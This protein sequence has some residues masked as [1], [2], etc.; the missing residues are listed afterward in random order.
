MSTNFKKTLATLVLVAVA[1]FG[2]VAPKSAKADTISDL[3]AQIAALMA[4]ISA[5]SGSSMTTTCAY[6][7]TVT[8]KV[9]STGS[10][11]SAMQTVIG[12][13]ADGKFGPNTK[14]KV[15]AFQASHGLVADGIVG[16]NTGAAMAASCTITT[17]T[18]TTTTTNN[19]TLS[20]GVGALKST[21]PAVLS[22][23]NNEQVGEG[24]NNVIVAGWEL[25][26]DTGSDLKISSL[27]MKFDGTANGGSKTFTK[28]ADTV[29][30]W[31]DGNKVAEM[32]ASDFSKDST[33][34]YSS[35]F[36]LDSSAII[37]AG[38]KA[39][40]TV[41]VSAVN[42]IDS[43]NLDNNSAWT[44]VVENVRYMDASG[45]ILTETLS[46]TPVAM[47]FTSFSTSSDTKLKL[48]TSSD[49]P[50]SRVVVVDDS[51][52]TDNVVLLKGTIKLEGNSDVNMDSF[53]VTLTTTGATDPSAVTG[54]LTLILDGEEYSE[55]VTATTS[56]ATVTFDNLDFDIGA[57]DTVN[58]EV[59]ANINDI[60][61][62][63]FDEGDQLKA[64]VTSNNRDA[65]DVTND[66]GDQLGSSEMSGT[67]TGEYQ[68][69]R[70]TG[71]DVSL[72]S[73]SASAL[74]GTGA[75]DDVGQYT[76]KFKVTAIGDAAYL[77]TTVAKGFDYS[78]DVGGVTTATGTSAVIVNNTDTNVTP[79]GNYLIEE[80][81][82]ETFTMTVTKTAGTSGSSRASLTGVKWDSSD[83]DT[84]MSK[85]Y[86][87]NLD[88]FKTDYMVLN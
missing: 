79:Q 80:G 31:L 24:E 55:V 39:K 14:A 41:A 67:S 37:K 8:L 29:S 11:V 17:T 34:V 48:T 22:Q 58:F 45:A 62:G 23:Y 18:T 86:S 30:V 85:T 16:A 52:N 49:T 26:A 84:I 2:A 51:N 74:T 73:T 64:T 40:L 21:S 83:A 13:T 47:K 43:T 46:I 4:Q 7:H 63:S 42:T 27:R 19:G 10:Q 35:N 32:D 5:L 28:Y 6:N 9:G 59:R 60:E 66:Q 3:Q 44:V 1:S 53:P 78:V 36:T 76:I 38:H 87:S 15:M 56:A 82:S 72:V 81:Q 88:S 71:I 12:A 57:G 68:I 75:N 20:G 50:S 25:E 77:G 33:G 61:A 65:I 69:F 54:S 70:T